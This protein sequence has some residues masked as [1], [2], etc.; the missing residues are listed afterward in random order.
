MTQRRSSSAS[1]SFGSQV[2]MSTAGLVPDMQQWL[3]TLH[4]SH[5]ELVREM[6]ELRPEMKR[7]V[8]PPCWEL[9]S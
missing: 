8:I 2:R 6:R 1:S 9:C 4:A 7:T 5:M 3:S